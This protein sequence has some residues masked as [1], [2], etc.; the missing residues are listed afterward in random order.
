MRDSRTCGAA[1]AA[2]VSRPMPH[3]CHCWCS[4]NVAPQFRHRI[5]GTSVPA[6]H[7]RIAGTSV[8]A[9]HHRIAD[10]SVPAQHH[11]I[12]DTS[13][14]AQHHRIATHHRIADTSGTASPQS[15]TPQFRHSI[16][17]S[18][19]PQFRHSITASPHRCHCRCRRTVL[20]HRAATQHRIAPRSITGTAPPHRARP[21][22]RPLAFPSG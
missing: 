16:T 21:R 10:T 20:Y 3:S 17:A 18:P 12:A 2:R 4:C 7:H 1:R 19:T 22:P 13:V 15:P 11:R 8:P 6:Q 5:A 14:P 9:Q